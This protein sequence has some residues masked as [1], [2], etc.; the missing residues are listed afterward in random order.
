MTDAEAT[1]RE[2]DQLTGWMTRLERRIEE[3]DQ[4][5]TRG[6]GAVV[7]QIAGL[8][9][10]LGEVAGEQRAAQD[11]H[12]RQHDRE[13]SQRASG[14]RWLITLG[15]T[16][17]VAV[18]GPWL[19]VILT[20]HLGA[21]PVDPIGHARPQRGVAGV[22]ITGAGGARVAGAGV[23]AA[24]PDCDDPAPPAAPLVDR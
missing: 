10:D 12:R 16:N 11:D 7:T 2:L 4:L 6:M 23:V 14:R 18:L 21:G 5:G 3:L 9:Q 24:Q 22:G 8:A 17:A 19:T 1:R 15:V 13:Q 20:R